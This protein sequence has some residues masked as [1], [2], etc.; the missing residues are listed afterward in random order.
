MIER[1][2]VDMEVTFVEC[3]ERLSP[4]EGHTQ[5]MN[6]RLVA[7]QATRID[8][9]GCLSVGCFELSATFGEY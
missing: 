7:E 5:Q 3:A 9:E 2:G 6:V 8:E 4:S 1:T